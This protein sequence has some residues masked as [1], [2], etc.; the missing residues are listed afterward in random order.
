MN[1]L[2]P[3]STS[4]RKQFEWSKQKKSAIHMFF[5]TLF[6][7]RTSK[8]I[9]FIYDSYQM[10]LSRSNDNWMDD[11]WM[12]EQC[13]NVWLCRIV[14]TARGF[15]ESVLNQTQWTVWRSSFV[16]VIHTYSWAI[17]CLLTD[18]S[19]GQSSSTYHV[20]YRNWFVLCTCSYRKKSNKLK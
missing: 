14:S 4:S 16:F 8:Q 15:H 12:V 11:N 20:Q 2:R 13:V 10:T 5:V 1:S 7:I 17:T 6:A 18:F 9:N 19:I 3:R